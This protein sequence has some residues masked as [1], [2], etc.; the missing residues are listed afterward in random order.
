M[1][2]AAVLLRDVARRL[3]RTPAGSR[4]TGPGLA[5]LTALLPALLLPVLLSGCG[6]QS[7]SSGAGNAPTLQTRLSGAVTAG[8][9]R[10][11]DVTVYR[12]DIGTRA[13]TRIGATTT[14][15]AGLYSLVVD[16]PGPFLTV[17]T[18]GS[19]RDEATGAT[20]SLG[21]TT[22]LRSLDDP[23]TGAIEVLL[24]SESAGA[25]QVANVNPLTRLASLRAATAS[26][27]SATALTDLGVRALT[28]EVAREFGFAPGVDLRRIRPLDFTSTADA[29]AIA[30]APDS[31]E[32]RLGALLAGLSALADNIPL[33][34]SVVSPVTGAGLVAPAATNGPGVPPLELIDALAEDARD[35]ALD[36]LAPD[37]AGGSGPI[38]FNGGELDPATGT[39]MLAGATATFLDNPAL[40]MSGTTSGDFSGLLADINRV[41]NTPA[42]APPRFDAIA[43]PTIPEDSGELAIDLTGLTAGTPAEDQ[44]GQVA[45]LALTIDDPQ[46]CIAVIDTT[47]SPPQ[48]KITPRPD[49]SGSTRLTVVATDSVNPPGLFRRR[50]SLTVTPVNDPPVFQAPATA[51][52]VEDSSVTLQVTGLDVGGSGES[53]QALALTATS[54]DPAIVPDPVVRGS[55]P[56]RSIEI[57]PVADASGMV[58][59]T[60]TATDDGG[61]A[62]GGVDTSTATLMLTVVAVNDAPDF[63]APGALSVFENSD[64]KPVNIAMVS[65]GP[66]DESGQMVTVTATSS[67]PA[68]IPDPVVMGSDDSRTLMLGPVNPV[69]GRTRVTITI[70]ATDDGGVAGG[71]VDTRTRTFDVDV[72]DLPEITNLAV[73]AGDLS[74]C[75]EISY[76]LNSQPGGATAADIIVEVSASASGP[77]QRATQAGS[78][79]VAGVVSVAASPTGTDHMFLWNSTRDFPGRDS[80]ELRIR[81]SAAIGGAVGTPSVLTGLPLANGFRLGAPTTTDLG[82][83]P[84]DLEFGDLD[85]DGNVDAVLVGASNMISILL[86]NPASPGSF[87]AP[88]TIAVGMADLAAVAIGDL[89]KDGKPDLAVVTA[90]GKLVPLIRDAS[91]FAFAA[92]TELTLGAAARDLALRD[93]DGDGDLDAAIT[94]VDAALI[95]VNNGA[96]VLQ[97]DTASPLPVGK[98]PRLATPVDLALDSAGDRLLTFEDS[99]DALVAIGLTDGRRALVSSATAGAG[100]VFTQLVSLALDAGNNR[101]LGLDGGLAALVAIDLGSGDRTI[102][103]DATTGSGAVLSAPVA[104]ALD[105][106]SAFV[107]TGDGRL[108]QVNLATG[109]RSLVSGGGQGFGTAL[110][111][112]VAIARGTAGVYVLDDGLDALVL[113]E[114]TNGNRQIISGGGSGTGPALQTPVELVLDSTGNRALVTDTGAAAVLAIDLAGGARTLVSDANTGA[115]DALVR[116]TALAHDSANGRLLVI[117]DDSD[118]IVAVDL[119]TGDRSTL[120]DNTFGSELGSLLVAD[121]NGDGGRDLLITEPG[122]SRLSLLLRA[123]PAVSGVAFGAPSTI[124]T[125]ARPGRVALRDVNDDGRPD[126]LIP[127]IDANTLTIRRGLATA[128]AFDGG[129]DIAVADGPAAVAVND[130]DGDGRLDL[131][132]ADSTGQTISILLQDKTA[133]GTFAGPS[134]IM[135][136][137]MPVALGVRDFDKNGRPDV[138]VAVQGAMRLSLIKSAIADECDPGFTGVIALSTAKAPRRLRVADV[139]A[140]GKPDLLTVNRDSNSLSL[141][142]GLGN[143]R[144]APKSDIMVSTSPR[145]F[146]IGDLNNDGIADLASADLGANAVSLVL[147]TAPGA[148]GAVMPL[149]PGNQPSRVAI[150]DLNGDGLNDL[151]VALD[152]VGTIVVLRQTAGMAGSF[153][154]PIDLGTGGVARI[155]EVADV[156]A[157]GFADLIYSNL[158]SARLSIRF[159]DRTNPGTLL[160]A[161]DVPMGPSPA[162]L[163]LADLDGNGLLDVAVADDIADAVVVALQTAPG[164]LNVTGPFVAGNG[165]SSV[166]AADINADGTLDLA[167]ANENGNTLAVLL[168]TGGG[169]FG[170]ATEISAGA[171]PRS[172]GAADVNGDGR[173]DLLSLNPVTGSGI[174]TL[175]VLSQAS[176]GPAGV[177]NT[178][179]STTTGLQANSLV[180]VDL[181]LDG[182]PEAVTAGA[183][184]LSLVSLPG[185]PGAPTGFGAAS[186]LAVIMETPTAITVGD[187]DGNG[188]SDFVTVKSDPFGASQIR[189]VVQTAPGTFEVR[190]TFDPTMPFPVPGV[191]A[192]SAVAD[193]DGDGTAEVIVSDTPS[194]RLLVFKIDVST[195]TFT[196]D[197]RSLAG[198]MTGMSPTGVAAADLDGDGLVDLLAANQA[199]ISVILQ[200]PMKPGQFLAATDLMVSGPLGLVVADVNLDGK[201]DIVSANGQG[202]TVSIN[203][204]DA[205]NPGQFAAATTVATGSNPVSVAVADLDGDGK[206]DIVTANNGVFGSDG[207][208]VS[209][210]YQDAANPG[211]FLDALTV[212]AGSR[213]SA[214][215]IADV[216]GDGALDIVVTSQSDGLLTLLKGG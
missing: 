46:L 51:T 176:T 135:V 79:S 7:S 15:A 185:A 68:V 202:N 41:D 200:D 147:A 157:D 71:G 117:D 80:A 161:F 38:A 204:Q 81:V 143:G 211:M 86:Q 181:D 95:A 168:G 149:A 201:P 36:G 144:F 16:G 88:Q 89:N 107:M 1:T 127:S 165:A 87:Q 66:A 103:S 121:V 182:A 133:A 55:G 33:A 194:N 108:L 190:P 184:S 174:D 61:T 214:V 29:A 216:D 72:M 14:D 199:S 4:S 153:D 173:V 47:V 163:T 40:N 162:G 90:D 56:T 37:P 60:L 62:D 155:L 5:R 195:G 10:D 84:G 178:A 203:L 215:A 6:D 148:Y 28:D 123:A 164:V 92:G 172:I 119:A 142:K 126:L 209:I 207:G 113:I 23:R 131:V 130:V 65:A 118:R 74:S 11:A 30:A 111:A 213:P 105:G 26:I 53:H 180:L 48:L 110:Q 97:L 205:N 137:P 193:L 129:T 112:P 187:L 27:T 160:P 75:V 67:L 32:A 102:I 170:T 192:G 196:L 159:Q 152:S 57:T 69:A 125:G 9:V 101:V 21:A 116:P 156:N 183:G 25:D 54:S 22:L 3:P 212:R 31:P 145:D 171:R 98:H 85:A 191:F 42:N 17:A 150:G 139:N 154:A 76:T 179:P 58:T 198:I 146:A 8:P 206:P 18:G 120:S 78:D 158:G 134:T 140:D 124:S 44:A 136:G 210:A 93:L 208:S 186:D 34:G 115:G 59:L 122:E 13:L 35:G 82:F 128:G 106:G 99:L 73:P 188:L 104:L 138:A 167:T 77:W 197:P 2:S 175:T 39:T 19:F 24:G 169:G 70:T 91:T 63:T 141:F 96:G 50:L 12:I 177:F 166:I 83:E 151:A 100:T 49:R 45:T 189:L 94:T 114:L 20:L 64:A 43:D 109:D 52:V 132:T